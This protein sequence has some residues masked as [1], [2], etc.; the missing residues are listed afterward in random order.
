MKI[1]ITHYWQDYNAE[2][3]WEGEFDVEVESETYEFL[4]LTD[5]ADAIE[6]DVF[7]V[8]DWSGPPESSGDHKIIYYHCQWPEGFRVGDPRYRSGSLCIEGA[9][10]RVLNALIER[11]GVYT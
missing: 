7:W 10:P 2:D 1:T 5:C 11:W 9:S 4:H 3:I 6:R 8:G